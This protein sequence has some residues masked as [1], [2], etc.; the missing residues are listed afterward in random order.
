M[1]G[2][3]IFYFLIYIT[4]VSSQS[5]E[6]AIF[7]NSVFT[8]Y[9]G[10]DLLSTFLHLSII[11]MDGKRPGLLGKLTHGNQQVQF[12][13]V[14]QIFD[15]KSVYYYLVNLSFSAKECQCKLRLNPNNSTQFIQMGINLGIGYP[16]GLLLTQYSFFFFSWG[17]LAATAGIVY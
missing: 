2:F 3:G 12:R 13:N 17:S 14:R 11:I 5:T 6:M 8:L 10:E 15:S 4:S 16:L 7:G 1:N 9:W